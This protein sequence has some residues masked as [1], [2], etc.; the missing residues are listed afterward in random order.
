MDTRKAFTLIELLVVISV[1]ALLMAVL[2]PVLKAAKETA[3]GAICASNLHN[4]AAAWF[5]YTIENDGRL[6]DGDVP[7]STGGFAKRT[8]WVTPPMDE[9][10]RY[11]GD[12]PLLDIEDKKRG[13]RDGTLFPYVKDE[14]VYHCPADKRYR[15]PP[16]PAFDGLDGGYR[17]YSI[18]DGLSAEGD[19]RVERYMQIKKPAEKYV[20]IEEN[21]MRAFNRGS[22]CLEDVDNFTT[23]WEWTDPLAAWHNKKSTLGWADGHATVNRWV[24]KAT[25]KLAMM[26]RWEPEDNPNTVKGYRKS[27]DHEGSRDL[28]FMKKHYPHLGL[29]K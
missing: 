3:T 15:Q 27:K 25:I 19:F 10:G 20:F 28:I 13:I 17:S 21:D 16:D 7:S 14:E 29:D 1:I 6:V 23:A 22:W 12:S 5:T 4:L 2:I 18:P 11:I 8:F 9:N 26:Y 24:E